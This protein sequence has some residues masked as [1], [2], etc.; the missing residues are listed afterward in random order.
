MPFT[1]VRLSGSLLAQELEDFRLLELEL[2]FDL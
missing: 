2:F 1:I